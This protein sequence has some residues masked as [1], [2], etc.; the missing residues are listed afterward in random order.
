MNKVSCALVEDDILSLTVVERLAERTGLL[1]I[2][3]KFDSPEKALPWL[4]NNEVDLLFL[5]VEM[6]GMTG[7]EIIRSLSYKPDVIII[8]GKS[9]YAAEAYDLSVIDYLVKPIKDYPRFLSAI[10]KVIVKKR[11]HA[12]Q[13]SD[14]E[15]LFVKVD[16]L[17]LQV[18]LDDVLWIEAFG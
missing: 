2:M 18:N 13:P 12:G 16:S 17:L 5:D 3:G 7:L 14:D 9:N 1:E 11:M 6:P 10:N 8:S 15:R 4:M